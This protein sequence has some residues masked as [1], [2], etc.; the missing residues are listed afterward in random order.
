MAR[1]RGATLLARTGQTQEEIAGRVGVSHVA[2]HH[3]LTGT[4][5][6][7]GKKRV[8]LLEHYGIPEAAWDEGGAKK[9]PVSPSIEAPSRDAGLIPEGVLGK[10]AYLEERAYRLLV[11]L[12]E[13]ETATPLEQGKVMASVATTLNLLARLTGQF[14]L[15]ARLF[16]LPIWK[17]IEKGLEVGLTGHPKAAAAVARELRRLEDEFGGG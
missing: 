5:K 16:K 9:A 15:G 12:D 3:W 2:V 13:D 14:E 6:P 4:T 10:A 1:S 7:A 17:R 11:S 8:I